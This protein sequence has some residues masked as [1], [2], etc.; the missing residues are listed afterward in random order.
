MHTRLWGGG[1]IWGKH[2][3][4]VV[5]YECTARGE[6]VPSTG[7]YFPETKGMELWG[8]IAGILVAVDAA[9]S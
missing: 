1:I 9:N 2:V 3:G 6:S 4:G 7:E 5:D 8:I